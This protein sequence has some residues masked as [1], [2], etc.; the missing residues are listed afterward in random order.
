MAG[1]I[2]N[3]EA[4]QMGHRLMGAAFNGTF[5]RDELPR[6][7]ANGVYIINLQASRQRT[8]DGHGD[9]THW[10]SLLIH[11]PAAFYFD[12]FG[13]PPP[14]SVATFARGTRLLCF[15]YQVQPFASN[16]CGYFDLFTMYALCT[17]NAYVGS[18]GVVY[19]A[20]NREPLYSPRNFDRNDRLIKEF[21]KSVHV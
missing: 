2:T 6:R 18:D 20:Y 5:S 3:V 14:N 9:G 4:D 19:K 16:L 17:G 11:G 15:P 12:S 8:Y 1:G 10:V 21:A 13:F 7:R